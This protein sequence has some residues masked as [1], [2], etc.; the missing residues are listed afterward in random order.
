[1]AHRGLLCQFCASAAAMDKSGK[2]EAFCHTGGVIPP[3]AARS[4]TE[5]VK[6][7][8][9]MVMTTA[10]LWLA[11][12]MFLLSGGRQVAADQRPGKHEHSHK[13][14]PGEKAG[15][16]G[17][18]MDG[19]HQHPWWETPPA[20]YA[21]A[22]STRWGDAAAIT[23]GEQLFQTYCLM[24]HGADGKGTGPIAKGLPHPPA[25]LTHH[26]HRAP[27][28]GDAYLFWRVS[29]GGQ[30]E[31]FKSSQSTMPAFK[32]VL[33]EEQRWDVLAYVHAQFHKGF[34]PTSATNL[35]QSVSGE[36]KVIAVVPA[37]QQLVVEHGDIPGFMEAMTMGYK[38]HPS[39]LLDTLKAGEMIRFTIDTQQKAIVQI[40][41]LKK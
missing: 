3:A 5:D 38:V 22:R 17:H 34:L 27:G 24:C 41:K 20:E 4:S 2:R 30:V 12:M 16:H 14:P 7:G 36:G 23:R 19:A 1:M 8:S 9:T 15:E 28:D 37:N 33:S 11:F 13:A 31:P 35:P 40:E 29:E 25:D 6:K 21:S 26:F 39:S 18:T 10:L 32:S